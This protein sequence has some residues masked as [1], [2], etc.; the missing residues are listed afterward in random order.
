MLLRTFY[1]MITVSLSWQLRA[2]GLQTSLGQARPY[3]GNTDVLILHI[4]WES[5]CPPVLCCS[6]SHLFACPH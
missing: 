2:I 3:L 4:W 1:S 6:H 5:W